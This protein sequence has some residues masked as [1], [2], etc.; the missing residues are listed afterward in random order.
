MD[1]ITEIDNE[2]VT[3]S[4]MPEQELPEPPQSLLEQFIS[5]AKVA[6]VMNYSELLTDLAEHELDGTL[7]VVEAIAVIDTLVANDQMPGGKRELKNAYKKVKSRLQPKRENS[8]IQGGQGYYKLADD[9]IYKL[10]EGDALLICSKLEVLAETRTIESNGWGRLLEWRDNDHVLHRWAMPVTLTAGDGNEAIRHLLDNGLYIIPGRAKNVIDYIMSVPVVQKLT[11]TDK[12]G[13]HHDAFVTSDKVYGSKDYVFQSEAG[14]KVPVSTKGSLLDWQHNVAAK[15]TGNSRIAFA[16]SAAL[17]GALLDGAGVDSGGFNFYGTSSDGKSSAL[18]IAAS[19]WGKPKGYARSWR[20]TGNGIEAIAAIHN[21]LPLILDDIG[22]ANPK[23]IGEIAYMLGNEQGKARAQRNGSA[24][25]IAG[26]RTFVLSSGE[27]TVGDMMKGEGKRAYAG[28]ELRI[29]NISTN[30]GADMGIFEN[31]YDAETPAQFADNLKR[32]I[33]DNYGTAGD[34]WLKTLTTKD[35]W[36]QTVDPALDS[37]VQN[38]AGGMNAQAG[39]VARRFALVAFA[40]ELATAEGIT[41]WKEGEATRAAKVC[42]RAWL[43]EYGK[44]NREHKNI[45]EAVRAFV[46]GNPAR[47]LKVYPPGQ[48]VEPGLDHTKPVEARA[49]ARAIVGLVGYQFYI[50]QDE[51]EYYILAS[52]IAE[53]AKGYKGKEIKEALL[54]AGWIDDTT[55]KNK[56]VPRIGKPRCF[57]LKMS[58]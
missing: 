16:I 23:D 48:I 28:Q 51:P 13:W 27:C 35:E 24:A 38:E 50:E 6:T 37:F 47:F 12:T 7:D 56:H 5:R 17:A 2:A 19:V 46:E 57:K 55:A 4:K 44:G 21:D 45:C 25:D 39:R 18:L 52:N 32:D 15:A 30:A 42:F 36:R 40:G 8:G 31:T 14:I 9:G 34:A 3:V 41:G 1:A 26:W 20:A 49:E 43:N 22:Q 53:L 54:A 11:N 29:A 33:A 10:T 58:A